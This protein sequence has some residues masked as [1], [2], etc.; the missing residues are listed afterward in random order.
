MHSIE[1]VSI[2]NIEQPSVVTL[3]QCGHLNL[4][5]TVDE[6]ELN[7]RLVLKCEH[8]M[9][10]KH[11]HCEDH[12]V[13]RCVAEQRECGFGPGKLCGCIIGCFC[14][15]ELPREIGNDDHSNLRQ[16]CVR[17]LAQLLNEDELIVRLASY[18]VID[19]RW[20]CELNCY[21]CT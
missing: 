8:D 3:L 17:Y 9:N 2:R 10:D 19:C 1:S 13:H 14:Q 15:L 12:T 4:A 11:F 16:H 6:H 7:L 5:K 20:I 18:P 21:P